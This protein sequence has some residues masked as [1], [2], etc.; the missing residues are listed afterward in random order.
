MYLFPNFVKIHIYT[1]RKLALMWR[2]DL[3]YLATKFYFW[4]NSMKFW[5]SDYTTPI[6]K[7][8][9]PKHT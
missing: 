3:E 1:T 4:P 9:Q 8:Q 2:M 5:I 7:L 6:L